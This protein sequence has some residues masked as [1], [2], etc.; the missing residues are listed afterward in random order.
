MEQRV[1]RCLVHRAE[2]AAVGQEDQL[3]RV[4]HATTAKLLDLLPVRSAAPDE[5][6]AALQRFALARLDV[7]ATEAIGPVKPAVRTRK[8]AVNVVARSVVTK[9][10]DQEL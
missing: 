1:P 9:P 6:N 4:I 10:A 8:R 3:H 2:Q 5:R 7:V